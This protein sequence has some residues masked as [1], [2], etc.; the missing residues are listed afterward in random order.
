MNIYLIKRTD[1][2]SYDDY[3]SFVVIAETAIDA[4]N[5]SPAPPFAS[6]VLWKNPN[7]SWVTS[8]DKLSCHYLGKADSRFITKEVVCVSF[9][10]G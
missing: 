5:T 9:N 4:C 6:D 2:Y 3:D 8:M 10:A 1:K 7:D